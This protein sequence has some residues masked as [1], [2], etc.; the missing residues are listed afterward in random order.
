MLSKNFVISSFMSFISIFL[1]AGFFTLANP[2]QAAETTVKNSVSTDDVVK[3]TVTLPLSHAYAT[4]KN[5]SFLPRYDSQAK[6][7]LATG[8]TAFLNTNITV[9]YEINPNTLIEI[10]HA[11]FIDPATKRSTIIQLN[12]LGLTG[13]YAFM[14]NAKL[15]CGLRNLIQFEISTQF[16]NPKV[17]LILF[18]NDKSFNS[19]ATSY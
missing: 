10:V 8:N 11:T 5:G 16:T 2:A 9:H 14:G 15:G 1:L 19:L 12:T 4:A 17:S 13:T 6:E 7:Q 3:G 18:N